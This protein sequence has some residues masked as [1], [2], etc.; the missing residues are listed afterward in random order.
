MK[1]SKKEIEKF[2]LINKERDLKSFEKLTKLQLIKYMYWLQFYK[3]T[4]NNVSKDKLYSSEEILNSL[5]SY[6]KIDR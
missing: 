6:Y 2:M 4:I 3:T 1:I 5:Y